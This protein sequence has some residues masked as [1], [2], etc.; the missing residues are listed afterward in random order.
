MGLL[1]SVSM[2]WSICGRRGA[3]PSF[4][5]TELLW[6]GSPENSPF[7]DSM[8]LKTCCLSA[9]SR[10]QARVVRIS[11][12]ASTSHIESHISS[13]L[14]AA[15]IAVSTKNRLSW[16]SAWQSI[17]S[18]RTASCTTA[19]TARRV[20]SEAKAFQPSLCGGDVRRHRRF[21]RRGFL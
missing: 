11:A 17:M 15:G 10:M 19:L 16:H 2:R 1:S 5:M 20:L 6:A 8:R 21:R 7:W 9:S 12:G 13:I 3:V 14:E 4:T 18:R